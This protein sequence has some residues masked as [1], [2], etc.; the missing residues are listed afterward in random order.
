LWTSSN[1]TSNLNSRLQQS[2]EEFQKWC[3][4]WKLKLQPTKTEMVHFSPH[5]RKKYKNPVSIQI[6]DT[7]I[8]PLDSTRYLGV[9]IDKK[10]NWRAHLNHIETKIAD[11]IGLL[12]FLSR[13]SQ[14][15]NN[16]I[17]L[18]IYKAIART[19]ITYGFPVL[20]TANNK[21]WERL[22]ILQ[23]KAIRAAL[24]L[25]PYT[26]VEYIHKL[27][28]IPKI[29]QYATSLLYKAIEKSK[30][31]NEKILEALLTDILNEI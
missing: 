1:T 16:M 18:N 9:I 20:I 11:R 17:I 5:P 6:E 4:S 12:R 27:S 30:S 21:F 2:V 29:K 3:L 25:P 8:K 24:G 31:N 26:S 15:P 7:K 13:S 19:I 22:Q 10:L 28:K 23:N 14:E